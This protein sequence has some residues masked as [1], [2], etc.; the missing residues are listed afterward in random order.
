M[1]IALDGPAASGKSTLAAA[2]ARRLGYLFFDTGVMYRAVTLACF[3]HGVPLDEESAVTALAR[4]SHIEVIPA[5]SD[6]GRMETVLLDRDDVT[7]EIRRPDVDASVSIP[8]KYAGVRAEMVSQQRRIAAQGNIIMAGRDIGTVV[9]PTADVK[10]FL[11]AT[12]EERAHRRHT[13][14]VSRGQHS[15]F[16]D[17]LASMRERDRLDTTRAESPLKPAVDAIQIDSTGLTRDQT[18][19]QMLACVA[20][21]APVTG[22]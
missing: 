10:I 18:L 1:K 8:S 22:A 11:T 21:V 20:R 19:A 5:T 12:V 14:L 16:G 4:R 9:L 13:E 2:L 15:I 6:D 7:W 17:V 3:K